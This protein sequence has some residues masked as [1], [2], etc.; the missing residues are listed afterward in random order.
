M[1]YHKVYRLGVDNFLRELGKSGTRKSDTI[2][3]GLLEGLHRIQPK[4]R[5]TKSIN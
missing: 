4:K 1:L 2:M 3:R 5:L